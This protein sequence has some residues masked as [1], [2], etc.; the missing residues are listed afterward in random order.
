MKSPAELRTVLR[1]QWNNRALREGR[2][3]GAKDAWPLIVPIGR[4]SPALIRTD[5][6]AVKRHVEAWRGVK[7]GE[8]LW[9]SVRHRDMDAHVRIPTGWAIR[10]PSEW[11]DACGEDA[12]RR[13]F[14]TMAALVE[15]TDPVF[16][17]HFIRRRSLWR[18]K[19]LAEVVQAARL[20]MQLEPGITAGKPLRTLSM[21]GIDT[22]FFERNKALVAALLDIRF[23]GEASEMGLEA[24]LGAFAEGDHWVLVID[25]GG[26]LLPFR[27]QR[28]RTSELRE[29]VLPGERLLIVENESC[30]H[31]LPSLSN[32]LAV[33]GCGFDLAW[34]SCLRLAAKRIAYWGDIDT[35]GLQFLANARGVIGTLDALMMTVDVYTQFAGCAVREPVTASAEVPLGLNNSERSLYRL[36]LNESCG[37][38]EQE[39]LPEAFVHE[40]I[41]KWANGQPG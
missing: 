37:R 2:L 25:L 11:I 41:L 28:V 31:Q 36:L 30:Q 15:Q 4:L 19:P 5:L 7:V 34:A 13:E 38:L 9:Q 3:L 16:H 12:I 21:D 18:G 40:A 35:W 8:V 27:K 14:E 26:A 24:F 10:K 29:I 32:T 23:D 1:R 20:A 17:S 22:K 6:N 39:F 33:L